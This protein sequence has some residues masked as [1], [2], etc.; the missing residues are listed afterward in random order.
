[1]SDL[2]LTDSLFVCLVCLFVYS[3]IDIF[4]Y[5]CLAICKRCKGHVAELM[6]V[7]SSRETTCLEEAPSIPVVPEIVSQVETQSSEGSE[8]EQEER[9]TEFYP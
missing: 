4:I 9:V 8:Q 1:M 5:F 7:E 6:T 3:F 2:H